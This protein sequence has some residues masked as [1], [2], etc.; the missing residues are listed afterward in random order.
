MV[1]LNL[2]KQFVETILNIKG[3]WKV[4]RGSC[5][6]LKTA[7]I[8][9]RWYEN[10]SLL[11]QGSM[12]EEYK[13]I[14]QIIAA[15]K[16]NCECEL[17]IDSFVD[18]TPPQK[19]SLKNIN[20]F[21]INANLTCVGLAEVQGSHGDSTTSLFDNDMTNSAEVCRSESSSSTKGD[22]PRDAVI[23]DELSDYEG[24]NIEVDKLEL[25]NSAE[26]V[27]NT[28]TMKIID[29]LEEKI[30]NLSCDVNCKINVLSRDINDSR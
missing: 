10:G 18:Y 23:C 1:N 22:L 9:V 21:M 26:Q 15:V 3:K 13:G 17:D 30:E 24:V 8:T 11:I 5:K 19:P 14:L 28:L 12:M 7:D 25:A 20:E 2:L 16:P 27:P 4:Q 6:E 29:R